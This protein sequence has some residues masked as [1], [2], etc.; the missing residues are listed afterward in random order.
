MKTLT[1]SLPE[2]LLAWA[3]TRTTSSGHEGLSTYLVHLVNEDRNRSSQERLEAL[4][5]EGLASGHGTEMT[6]VDWESLKQRVR[7]RHEKKSSGGDS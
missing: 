5:L 4:L 6:P 7:E 2:E 3:E 1:V